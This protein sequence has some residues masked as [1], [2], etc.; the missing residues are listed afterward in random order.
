MILDKF[1][2]ISR[3]LFDPTGS[4]SP[5]KI[6]NE[7]I[8]LCGVANFRQKRSLSSNCMTAY[9]S[10]LSHCKEYTCKNE[11]H[12]KLDWRMLNDRVKRHCKSNHLY[13]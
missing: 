6:S 12:K 7:M 11:K 8:K 4:Q 13:L 10:Y 1:H 9:C 5:W 3:Y 2:K